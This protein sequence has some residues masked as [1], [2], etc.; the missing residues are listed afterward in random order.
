MNK[1]IHVGVFS[2]LNHLEDITLSSDY[3]ASGENFEKYS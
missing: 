1:F 2:A 3:A